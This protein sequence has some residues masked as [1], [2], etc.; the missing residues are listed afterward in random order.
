MCSVRVLYVQVSHLQLIDGTCTCMCTPLMHTHT[1]RYMC[2]VL[3]SI[4][5][6][7]LIIHVHDITLKGHER[8]ELSPQYPKL[9]TVHVD[10][11][12][13]LNFYTCISIVIV[14]VLS[15]SFFVLSNIAY[16]CACTNP[17]ATYMYQEYIIL[18]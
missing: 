7:H 5:N 14:K 15:S 1:P 10:W 12:V 11:T 2:S 18:S 16:M 9:Y 17:T 13:L 6:I 3:R 8:W 4:V